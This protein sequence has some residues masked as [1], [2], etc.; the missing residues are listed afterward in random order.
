MA[1]QPPKKFKSDGCSMFPDGNWG[2]CCIEHDRA[3][4]RGGTAGQRKQADEELRRCVAAKGH[5]HIAALMYRGVRLGGVPWLPTTWRW[6]FGWPW[7]K[8]IRYDET[9]HT[10]DA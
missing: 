10:A 4:W 3:Y 6:A 7:P 2:E 5:P 8:K 9:E 1:G